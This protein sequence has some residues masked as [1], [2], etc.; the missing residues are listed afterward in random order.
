MCKSKIKIL[1]V[2]KSFGTGGAEKVVLDLANGLNKNKYN[3]NI[4]VLSNERLDCFGNLDSCINKYFL[5]FKL[6]DIRSLSFWISGSKK[7]ITI[8]RNIRPD[9]IHTHTFFSHL[10]FLSISFR[11]AKLNFL[12]F[13]TIHS[14]GFY[15][16]CQKSFLNKIRLLSEKI[17]MM[18]V[19]T[20]LVSISKA[21]HES[22]VLH[23]N[24]IANEIRLIHNGID[25]KKYN[26][27]MCKNISKRDFK[28]DNNNIVISYVARLEVGKNHDFLID[29]WPNIVNKFPQ[30]VLCFAG[31]GS[32]EEF[33]RKKVVSNNLQKSII[34]LGSIN[35]IAELLSITDIGVFPSSFEGFSLVMLEKFAMSIP[36]VASDIKPF[37][38]IATNNENAFLVPITEKKLF[39]DK[40]IKL[41]SDESLRKK[42]GANAFYAAQRFSMESMVNLHEMYYSNVFFNNK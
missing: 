26:T 4:L 3:V 24:R 41:C 20:Y 7:I 18:L 23:F 8:L 2:I 36:I 21:A 14:T 33:L 39:T 34:F 25:L 30:A 9:I 27:Q 31:D 10:L 12:H 1:Y 17:A 29:L 32:L 37:R 13:R 6:N 42:I 15:Y 28:L 16:E 5:D 35:N 40:I 38:E 19:K 22:N 11:F